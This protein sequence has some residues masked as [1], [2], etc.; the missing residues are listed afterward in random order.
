[1][2]SNVWDDW[3][4][5]NQ[6]AGFID[7]NL[8]GAGQVFFQNNPWTGL[9]ILVAIFWGA[10][11]ARNLDVAFG[12]VAGLFISTFT[13][14][15]LRAEDVS[16]K[17]GLFGL[18]GILVG[19]AVPTYLASHPTMWADIVI[20]AAVSTVM[21]M[22]V[23][24]VVKTWGLPGST[25]PFVFTTQLLLLA[26]YAFAR[27]PISSMTAS[28]LP[29]PASSPGA[30]P[31]LTNIFN[32]LARNVSQIYLIGNVVTGALFLFAI[33]INSLRGA[34]FAVLGSFLSI[35]VAV[36]F[37][38][39][40]DSINAGL[41]GFCAVL[42]A[43][44]VGAVLNPPSTGVTLYAILATIFA[45]IVQAAM[46]TAMAPIGIPP[47]TFPYV[48]TMWLFQLPR[49]DLAVSPKVLEVRYGVSTRE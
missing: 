7:A 17:Q 38:A 33:A 13:A 23:G 22:A 36:G 26:A 29:M 27:V 9:I 5:R 45:V 3:A 14:L 42:T 16:V 48:L 31:S 20:G 2:V 8:R 35:V 28:A 46:N 39:S 47:L 6:I 30:W 11:A 24:K 19:A 4:N 44:A 34:V 12:A 41:Y 21:T 49:R 40:G 37:G 18:N 43:M 1:M 25:A 10:H 32:I 15:L